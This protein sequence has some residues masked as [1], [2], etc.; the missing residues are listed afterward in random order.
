MAEPSAPQ[1]NAPAPAAPVAQPAAQTPQP[2]QPPASPQ[3]QQ[4]PA[5]AAQPAQ[6]ALPA[7]LQALLGGQSLAVG[8][9]PAQ[10]QQP[11]AAQPPAQPAAPAKPDAAEE[12][13]K[14]RAQVNN[15]AVT[16]AIADAATTAQAI[17]PDQVVALLRDELDVDAN[18]RVFVKAD[19]RA[20]V[21][22]HVGKYLAANLHL[23]APAVK[24]GGSGTPATVQAP[25]AAAPPPPARTTEGGTLVVQSV[26]AN[27]L[28]VPTAPQAQP[29]AAQ[30]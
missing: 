20:D 3:G 21:G 30:R 8:V 1:P 16:K 10:P 14:L 28:R 17:K 11:P 25:G 13:A 22:A 7:G 6:P 12:V 19:P 15:A 27:L 5:A 29:P 4:A 23:L 24:G 26:V 18:G 9:A 2:A